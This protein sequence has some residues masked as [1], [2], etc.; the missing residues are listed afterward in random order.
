MTP[1]IL[2]I[3]AGAVLAG[4]IQGLSG[5]AYALIATA[6]WVWLVEPQ[7]LVPLVLCSSLVGQIA[8]G[9]TIKKHFSLSRTSPFLVGGVI[10]VPIG[11]SIFHQLNESIFRVGVGIVLIAYCLAM[12]VI[13][14]MPKLKS[15]GKFADG[16][17]GLISGVMG[18]LGGL[19]GPA[20]VIWCALRGWDK[21]IQ[22][23]TF[24]P[25]F[26]LIAVLTSAIYAMSGAITGET[27]QMLAAVAPAV[28]VSSWCGEKV[29]RAVPET[30]FRK[31]L[32]LLLL[33][34]GLTLV[35]PAAFKLI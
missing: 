31:L 27:W 5:F 17:V 35:A 13:A 12:L 22:R 25:L 23:A 8:S 4:F 21:S 1:L 20:P 16:T 14:D 3:I 24:Q 28:I 34:S 10:G 26:F 7:V 11:I 15:S 33:L 18:G 6:I 30:A 2:Q 9:H 32:L 29:Y 19:S